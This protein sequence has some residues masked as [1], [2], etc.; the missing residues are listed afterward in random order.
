MKGPDK[1]PFGSRDKLKLNDAQSIKNRLCL[2]PGGI[3]ARPRNG[4]SPLAIGVW[5][6]ASN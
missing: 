1:Q 5:R 2:A 3:W 6:P 4:D